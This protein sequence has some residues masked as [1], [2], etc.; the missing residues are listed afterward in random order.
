MHASSQ[1]LKN[2]MNIQQIYSRKTDD[3]QQIY[4][5]NADGWMPRRWSAGAAA[6]AADAGAAELVAGAGGGCWRGGAG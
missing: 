1:I 6:L 2:E 4:S 3:I 5:R